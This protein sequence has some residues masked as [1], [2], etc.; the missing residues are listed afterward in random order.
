M[1]NDEDECDVK[2]ELSPPKEGE[3]EGGAEKEHE[4][5]RQEG[6]KTGETRRDRKRKIQR[7]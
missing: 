5:A 4:R 1:D 7:E 6:R 2:D 3:N